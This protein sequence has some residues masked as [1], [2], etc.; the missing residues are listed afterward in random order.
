MALIGLTLSACGS[1][2]IQKG[3]NKAPVFNN[4]PKIN[5]SLQEMYDNNISFLCRAK[6]GNSEI[7]IQAKDKKL[8]VDGLDYTF[9]L[10]NSIFASSTYLY[11]DNMV[12]VWTEKEGRKLSADDFV[13]FKVRNF[14]EKDNNLT[15]ANI[16][17]SNYADDGKVFSCQ[18]KIFPDDVFLPT[19]KINFATTT[20]EVLMKMIG[21][22]VLVLPPNG[23]TINK[24]K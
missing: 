9:S 8:R 22:P 20:K 12:Y 6:F 19:N 21:Q 2:P 5:L 4:L 3:A 11:S 15:V 16:L 1:M 13:S 24:N 18:D 23:A 7:V 10:N 14:Y 17:L